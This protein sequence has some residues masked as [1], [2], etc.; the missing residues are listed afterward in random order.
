MLAKSM[1]A[2]VPQVLVPGGGDQWE[3]AQRARRWGCAEV[4]RPP[5][6]G[7]MSSAIRK[8]LQ[9]NSFTAAARRAGESNG[10]VLDPVALCTRA[11]GREL[12]R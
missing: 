5:T 12:F 9:S 8:I 11:A 10:D 6:V 2:G 3:L 7:A 4:V 1:L